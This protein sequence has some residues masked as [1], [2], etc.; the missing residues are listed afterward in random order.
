MAT[1]T[2]PKRMNQPPEYCSGNALVFFSLNGRQITRM[3]TLSLDRN[4]YLLILQTF[5]RKKKIQTGSVITQD[6]FLI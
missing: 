4:T 5:N 1:S 2:G 6:Y 3:V